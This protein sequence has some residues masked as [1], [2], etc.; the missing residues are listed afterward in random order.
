M[1][2]VAPIRPGHPAPMKQALVKRIF[3]GLQKS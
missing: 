2:G 3:A 1:I